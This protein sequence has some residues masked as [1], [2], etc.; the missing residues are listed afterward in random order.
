MNTEPPTGDDLH[1]MLVTMKQSVLDR[2]DDRTPAPRRRGRRTGIVIGVIALLGLGATSGGVAL[3]MIPQPFAAAPAPTS[4]PSPTEPAAPSTPAAAPVEET[5]D[6][7]PTASATP[8]K[9]AFA[10]DDPSTWTISGTEMGPVAI[11]GPRAG[12][13]DDLVP[14]YQNDIGNQV[15]SEGI[16]SAWRR[17]DAPNLVIWSRDE[18]V[19][20][21][22]VWTRNDEVLPAMTG[23]TTSKGIGVGST[24][25][26]LHAAY[27][28]ATEDTS[29]SMDIEPLPAPN[30]YTSWQI[31][32]G[33]GPAWLML[34]ADGVHVSSIDIGEISQV[35]CD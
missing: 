11:G 6:P 3:G 12:E 30:A 13:T 5:P 35:S 31:D 25:D 21:V 15:C 16:G 34:G 4:T 24:L 10:L 29:R 32:T 18:V 14:A 26:E 33:S 20:G 8:T 27:P 1:R 17:T 23:P 7:T 9:G 2:A 19:I 28:G 22:S